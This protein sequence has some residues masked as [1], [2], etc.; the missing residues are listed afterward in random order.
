MANFFPLVANYSANIANGFV[1]NRIEELRPNDN[2]DFTGSGIKNLAVGNIGILGGLPGQVLATTGNGVQYWANGGTGGGS[3]TGASSPLIEFDVSTLHPGGGNNL[4]FTD[5][6]LLIYPSNTYASVYVNGVLQ[7]VT[8]YVI[9]GT[10]LAMNQ[11]LLPDDVVA[12]GPVGGTGATSVPTLQF[13]IA[14][15]LS[16]GTG[17][18]F[19]DPRIYLYGSNIN[20]AVFVNGVLQ[21]LQDYTIVGNVLT[22]NQFLD[23]DDVVA[24]GPSVGLTTGGNI[25]TTQVDP[26]NLGFTLTG[27]PITSNGTIT[28]NVPNATVFTSAIGLSGYPPLNGNANTY[29]N[30]NGVWTAISPVA[31]NVGEIQFN[32]GGALAS[33][34]NLTFNGSTM[35]TTNVFERVAPVAGTVIDLATGAYQTLNL[36]ASAAFTLVNVPAAP[37]VGS[38]ILHLSNAANHTATFSFSANPIKWVDGIAPTLQS[39]ALTT[40]ILGFYTLDG[41]LNWFGYVL[42]Q[43]VA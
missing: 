19:T 41:G 39:S 42:G 38:F 25:Q 33:S 43:D 2:L 18:T 30:G 40:D 9:S 1:G 37:Q 15:N 10:T 4:S 23:V 36:V 32:G 34:P 12:V 13:P 26:S 5:T 28:L 3:P 17:Q 24:I 11:E 29:L 7:R 22:I 16:P 8:D 35:S 27:G 31:G 21:R 6:N 20:A 14:G